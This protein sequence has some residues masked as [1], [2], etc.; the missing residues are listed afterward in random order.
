MADAL[1]V[2]ST[3]VLR[4]L[5]D[6]L[7]EK[8]KNAALEIEGIVRQLASAGDHDKITAVINL[9]TTEF[10][11]SPQANHRK[12]GLI[13]LAA[14]T[15]GLSNDAAQ[16]LEQIV[17]PVLNSFSDQDSRVRYYACEALYNIAKVVRGDF[18]IFFNQIFDALCKLSADSDVNVQSAA[19]LLDRLVKDI[20]TESDQFSIEEFIPLLRE[21]MNVLN[22]FVRQFLV[23]W[24]T[25]L[26]SVPDIDM[27]GFLPDF[28]DGLFNMLSDSSHEI[29]QQA[30]SALSEFLQEIKNSPS[31]D[32]RRMAEILVQRADSPDEFT[33]LTAITWMNEFVK[34]GGDQLV[35]YYADI[36]GA[37]LPCIS[38]K[39]E[40]IRVVARET[41]EELRA[42]RADP[43]EGFDVGAILS[44]SKRQ[45]S[46]EWDA[47]RSEALQWI[48]T[49][50]DRH[51]AEVLS[52]LNEILDSLLKALSDKSDEV[53]L[54]VLEIHA[55]IAKDQHHFRQL[56]VFLVHKFRVDNTLLE[57][58]G[59][60]I[61]RKLCVLLN[62]EIVYRELSMILEGEADL[63]FASTMVQALNLILLTSSELTE[64]RDLLK[65][66]LA[67]D[68][69]KDLFVSLYAS[70]CHAP[71]AIISLCL[72]AQAYQ[73]A[74]VVIRSLGEEDITVRFLVQLD[75]LVRLL[76]TP[77]FAYL[78]LQLL[79]PG[80]YSWLLKVLYG[81]LMLL[82]QQSAAFKILR[83]R[84]KTVPPYSFNGD[85]M[86]TASGTYYSQRIHHVPTGS[87]IMEDGDLGVDSLA[88]MHNGINFSVRLQQFEQML[89]QH[90]SQ[91]RLQ[92]Q[93]H[94][95][96]LTSSKEKQKHEDQSSEHDISRPPSRT[97]RRGSGQ[98]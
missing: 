95:N 16:H 86:R 50:L 94:H 68:S 29:R 69:G 32:Y 43:A 4:N 55:C 42:I 80:R 67:N 91:A 54:L 48:L 96:N 62:A 18:I 30:D 10:T 28:L 6:K 93:Q 44:I 70:W 17:P 37:I 60:L 15:V 1:S 58:R 65:K 81:L 9:L 5:S 35:C 85:I 8:R 13:G 61:I 63:D 12:G 97:S 33:R 84:L 75:K 53:V 39:E 27:L 76:E 24:I 57:K 25:V 34:L 11:M 92:S 98:S 21:R 7:Y 71:M 87:Q 19:H 14:A 73:H 49:L 46:S 78:R 36:L 90:R 82:P 2:I 83:T 59:A 74:S 45:L 64:L 72:L 47:T 89:Q 22:P 3:S 38:D 88:N 23:G 31:V 79:D 26:D 52:Y 51:R 41:N 40:K 66:S 20:V 56:L 77:I